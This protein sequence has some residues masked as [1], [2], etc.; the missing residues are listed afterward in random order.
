MSDEGLIK[1]RVQGLVLAVSVLLM[2]GKF[3]AFYMTHSV[4]I[5]TDAMESIVNVVAGAISLYSLR[6]SALPKDKSHPFGHGKAELISASIEG[7]LI[8]GAGILMISEGIRRFF[9]PSGIANLDTGIVIVAAA[10]LINWLMGSYSIRAGK[11]YQSMALI[12][13]GK[14]L[15]SDTYST[16]GLIVGLL[17]LY[18]TQLSWIDSLLA[19]IFGGVILIT[20]YSILRQTVANLLDEADTEILDKMARAL[21]QNREADWIDIH[22]TKVVKYGSHLHIDCD[23]TLPWYY[24][25]AQS[26]KACEQL[27][28]T[29]NRVNNGNVSISV[30]SDPCLEQHCHH[31][32]VTD[33]NYRRAPFEKQEDLTLSQLTESDEERN[34]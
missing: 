7:L 16:I 10:G 1:Q 17:L 33:C 8:G 26:H 32:L 22:N 19:I 24:T 28:A 11:R 2:A 27:S 4:A 29:L 34:E 20:G 3:L 23:L 9:S 18:F 14:H 15:H 5:L 25:V 30:H 12:A 13:G 6:F 31:C 21:S